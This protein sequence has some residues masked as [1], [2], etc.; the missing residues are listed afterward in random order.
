MYTKH[1]SMSRAMCMLSVPPIQIKLGLGPC[2]CC[3]YER[4]RR[5][6][7]RLTHVYMYIYIWLM[8]KICIVHIICF[9]QL[10]LYAL[11]EICERSEGQY[12]RQRQRQRQTTT[13]ATATAT[14]TKPK[15]SCLLYT[16]RQHVYIHLYRWLRV[17]ARCSLWQCRIFVQ[18]LPFRIEA[19]S[20]LT[21]YSISTPQINVSVIINSILY[22]Y[23]IW[24][25]VVVANE[26][27][28]IVC[29]FFCRFFFSCCCGIFV[30]NFFPI[31]DIRQC[32]CP[33]Y[34]LII[35]LAWFSCAVVSCFA[36][37]VH[38][39]CLVLCVSIVFVIWFICFNWRL[40]TF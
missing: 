8:K 33:V 5:W 14:T 24:I 19:E 25:T 4:V 11:T 15:I 22:I 35:L 20:L 29:G 17:C 26:L 12:T 3:A 2:V 31:V 7:V 28:I 27:V 30:I 1:S 39:L 18:P 36:Y 38:R 13:T 23:S 32:M 6:C 37:F 40:F 21:V 9:L 34:K 10:P 16:H